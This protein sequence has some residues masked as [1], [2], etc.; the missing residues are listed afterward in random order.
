MSVALHHCVHLPFLTFQSVVSFSHGVLPHMVTAS[1]RSSQ[2]HSPGV[3]QALAY[4]P[5]LERLMEKSWLGVSYTPQPG[6]EPR[7]D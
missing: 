2:S 6:F 3:I 5:I 7:L 1:S 4:W